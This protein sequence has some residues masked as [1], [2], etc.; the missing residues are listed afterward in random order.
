MYVFCI[1]LSFSTVRKSK[2]ADLRRRSIAKQTRDDHRRQ[3]V[4][5]LERGRVAAVTKAFGGDR[6]ALPPKPKPRNLTVTSDTLNPWADLC[7]HSNTRP[8]RQSWGQFLL[9]SGCKLKLKCSSILLGEMCSFVGIGMSV[10]FRSWP[11]PCCSGGL[12]SNILEHSDI[13][14]IVGYVE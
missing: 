12:G 8:V 13:N 9:N 14:T 6:P 5:A 3:S 2:A 7:L 10:Y 11:Q 4:K 1:L